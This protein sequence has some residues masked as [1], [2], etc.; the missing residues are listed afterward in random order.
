MARVKK[1]GTAV[2][3]MKD[4]ENLYAAEAAVAAKAA[5]S[6]EGTPR[7]SAND[8]TFR[9][10]ELVLP[11]PLN[12]IVV[13][14]ALLN[15]WYEGDYDPDTAQAPSCFALG[16]AVEGGDK[17]MQ[18]DPTSPNKQGDEDGKCAG[19]E[20]NQFGTAERGR[21]KACSNR[22]RL[23]LVMADDPAFNDQQDL[24]YA[25]LD[26]SPTALSAWGKFVGGLNKVEHRPP[27]G[28]ITRLS[29]N[30]N[31]PVDQRRKAVVP[32]GYQPI[33]SLTMATKV[34]ALRKEVLESSVLLRPLPVTV[35]EKAAPAK[36]AR[37]QRAAAP[38][39][40]TAKPAAKPARGAKPAT[41]KPARF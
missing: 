29:F 9:I 4:L 33:T 3:T 17:L 34:H 13:A 23:C 6:A 14:E 19:C 2:A 1:P 7:I 38:V 40:P 28:V 30:K 8:Y 26:L 11:D 39:P 16:E 5:P 10:G 27:H 18:P 24:R 20:M 31:D 37:R 25:I 36:P 32:I 12:V 41:I 35:A 21:G 22:R 15:V